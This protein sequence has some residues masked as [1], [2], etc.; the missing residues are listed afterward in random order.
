MGRARSC[1]GT[2]RGGR[3]RRGA[4]APCGRRR[5]CGAGD[6]LAVQGGGHGQGHGA[7]QAAADGVTG[8][9]GKALVERKNFPQFC[10]KWADFFCWILPRIQLLGLPRIK[11]FGLLPIMVLGLG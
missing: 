6:R 9:L 10:V 3:R 4:A 11:V 5:R 1:R 8:A 2:P 7:R